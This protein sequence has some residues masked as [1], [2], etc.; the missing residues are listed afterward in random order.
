MATF[1]R[2]LR[3]IHTRLFDKIFYLLQLEEHPDWDNDWDTGDFTILAH[4]FFK[5]N[6][7]SDS[8]DWDTNLQ[9][10]E[11][12]GFCTRYETYPDPNYG[13]QW[14]CRYKV[15][16]FLAHKEAKLSWNRITLMIRKVCDLM[17]HLVSAQ[18]MK[19]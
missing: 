9:Y 17:L 16:L 19:L 8:F 1:I 13:K 18:K 12:C 7:I 14:F 6:T 5:Q 2:N 10:E 3:K 15:A 11:F 4:W